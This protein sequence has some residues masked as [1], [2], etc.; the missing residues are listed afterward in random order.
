MKSHHLRDSAL[1]LALCSIA[2]ASAN[3]QTSPLIQGALVVSIYG[4]VNTPLANNTYLD[5]NATP[6]SLEQ[7]PLTISAGVDN[8][9]PLL[10]ETLPTTGTGANVGIIGEYGSSSEG[11]ILLSGDG[12]FLT[13]GGYDGNQAEM[14]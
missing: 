7:F 10:R 14:E 1:A 13:I 8:G 12:R 5:G 6:I 11:T 4:K 9:T 3:A 2:A